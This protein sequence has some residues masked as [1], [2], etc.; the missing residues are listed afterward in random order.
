MLSHGIASEVSASIAP[1]NAEKEI[2]IALLSTTFSL[3]DG[4]VTLAT[5][6]A[7]ETSEA[8]SARD[9]LLAK[10]SRSAARPAAEKEAPSRVSAIRMTPTKSKTA[11]NTQ[12]QTHPTE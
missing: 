10:K 11:E 9:N 4:E 7:R 1:N 2:L 12:E 3:Q 6:N 5:L 8:S